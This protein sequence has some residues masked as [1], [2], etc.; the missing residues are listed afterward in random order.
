MDFFL[1]LVGLFVAIP[2]AGFTYQS[3]GKWQDRRRFPPPGRMLRCGTRQMHIVERGSG[4]TVVLE[5]GIASTS[6]AWVTIQRALADEARVIAYDRAGFGWSR[7]ARTP[8]TLENVVNDLHATLVESQAQAPYILVGHSYGGL[9]VRLFAK[10]YPE[11]VAGLLLV[12]AVE[13]RDWDPPSDSQ[14]KRL[15]RGVMLSK[16]GGLLARF[17][18]VRF[19]LALLLSGNRR[20][21]Q[22]ISRWSTGKGSSVTDRL[23]GEVRKLPRAVWPMVRMHWSDEKCFRTMAEYLEMLPANSA[24]AREAG[25]PAEI[26][27]IALTVA[28]ASPEFPGYVQHRIAARSGHWIQLDEPELVLQAVRELL[29]YSAVAAGR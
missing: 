27:A 4:P 18:V 16:R 14:R 17:G 20:L 10:R 12:D 13:T 7:R 28:N 23:V 8:R 2:L 19:A 5:A 26:P 21:P 6:L 29:S 22:L 25:W 15:G 1:A 9:I 24:I 3:F 11:L